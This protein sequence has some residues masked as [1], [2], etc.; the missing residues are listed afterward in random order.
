MKIQAKLA[1]KASKQLATER[2]LEESQCELD[3][4]LA[5]ENEVLKALELEREKVRMR[6][7]ADH[8]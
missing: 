8:Q 4:K 6:R 7:P 5:R 1:S 2:R 3:E